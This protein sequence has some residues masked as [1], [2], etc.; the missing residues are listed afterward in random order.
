MQGLLAHSSQR[1][2][3]DW[4]NW[5]ADHRTP[6][7]RRAFADKGPN[8]YMQLAHC[9]LRGPSAVTALE[10]QG[11]HSQA[12][13]SNHVARPVAAGDIGASVAGPATEVPV[14]GDSPLH[15]AGLHALQTRVREWQHGSVTT[16][17]LLT[18]LPVQQQLLL[19]AGTCPCVSAAFGSASR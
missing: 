9:A 19:L 5:P 18:D 14:L 1:G 11:K 4:L 13:N 2:Y 6:F 3:L 10:W 15:G 16:A 7:P 8:L 17:A 12:W